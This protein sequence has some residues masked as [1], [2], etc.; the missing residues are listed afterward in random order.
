M[1]L[2]SPRP[3]RFFGLRLVVVV[4]SL[5]IGIV[6]CKQDEGERCEVD[7]DCSS[8]L[9]CQNFICT[10][11]SPPAASG[12]TNGSTGG[13]GEGGAGG[14]GGF[15]GGAGAGG[16]GGEGGTADAPVGT[17]GSF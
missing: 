16:A 9:T 7:T 15:G 12:G 10:S 11:N 3:G 6:A 5:A 14:E 2:D 8:G 1:N 17:G 4:C 13:G